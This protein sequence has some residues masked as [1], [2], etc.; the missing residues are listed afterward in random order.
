MFVVLDGA[1][2]SLYP[3]NALPMAWRRA[4]LPLPRFCQYFAKVTISV[5]VEQRM[6][7]ELLVINIKRVKVLRFEHI[8]RRFGHSMRQFDSI[9]LSN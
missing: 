4:F 2:A 8:L 3:A 5:F 1:P 6:S 9:L 7:R